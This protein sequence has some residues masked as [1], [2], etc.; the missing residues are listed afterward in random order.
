MSWTE[1]HSNCQQVM[2]KNFTQIVVTHF[3]D[4]RGFATK[5]GNSTN[6]IC[7]RT[8]THFNRCTK[9][10]IEMKCSIGINESHRTLNERLLRDE[11]IV[12]MSDDINKCVANSYNVV[13]RFRDWLRRHE[14]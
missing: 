3:A 1:M 4:I 14:P 5:T 9:R 6:G 8:T 13:N 2:T 11:V 10:L 7:G 12:G